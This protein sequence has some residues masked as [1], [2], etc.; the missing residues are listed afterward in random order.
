MVT[1]QWSPQ[2]FTL[3]REECTK[4]YLISFSSALSFSWISSCKVSV[5]VSKLSADLQSKVCPTVS[6]CSNTLFQTDQV[7]ACKACSAWT[8]LTLAEKWDHKIQ[9]YSYTET[10]S[11]HFHNARLILLLISEI[12][13]EASNTT[14]V[15]HVTKK[16]LNASWLVFQIIISCAS[17][18]NRLATQAWYSFLHRCKLQLG[19]QTARYK[20]HHKIS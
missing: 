19:N 8:C 15:A 16:D 6:S 18:R 11:K 7:S 9:Q 2:F 17:N 20:S 3:H 14:K 4:S 1:K 5:S 12:Q 10:P 13:K